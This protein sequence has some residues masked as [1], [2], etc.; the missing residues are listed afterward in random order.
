MSSVS[1]MP[2]VRP[3]LPFLF[4]LAFL[5]S[6]AIPLCGQNVDAP[7]EKVFAAVPFDA[8]VK[9]GPVT[10]IPWKARIQPYGLSLHQRMRA[11]IDI[12][13]RRR[14][15]MNRQ[16]NDRMLVLVQIT[17]AAGEQF[18]EYV[19]FQMKDAGAG[20]KKGE[21]NLTWAV[22]V[23]PGDYQVTLV[24]VDAARD[25]H[26]LIQ[27]HMHVEPLKNDPLP[28]IWIGLPAVEFLTPYMQG[29]DA[30][31]HPEIKTRLHLPLASQHPV[32]F[33]VLADV[34]ASDLFH[35]STVFY[36]RYLA[37]ALPLLKALS[38]VSL[39]QGS[40]NVAMLD[41]RKRAVTF[42]EDDVKEL[43]WT[44]AK[45][46]L[47][48]ENGPSTIDIKALEQK[49]E[50]PAFLQ[51][52]LLR[53][54]NAPP[55]GAKQGVGTSANDGHGT[56]SNPL[57]VFVIIGSPMDFYSFRDLPKLPPGSEEK[58]VVYYLQFELLNTTYAD[59]AIGNV[60]KMLKPLT[61]HVFKVRSAESVRH[62][63]AKIL[64]EVAAM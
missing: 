20:T 26:N 19:L 5:F 34:T 3:Y 57:H 36:D 18:R 9:Q 51:D 48:P 43:D 10:A 33:D 44:R 35:G 52:E 7:V 58:C 39:E 24:L 42:E 16:P 29:P 49:R 2:L 61:V 62:A 4:A 13:L 22:Y 32:E 17:D 45:A 55:A 8:W 38:Q 63:L 21:I 30:L 37:V 41:L 59:G 15:L 23:L 28:S 11:Y 6:G 27:S 54:L 64:E 46:V 14:E 40:V 12:E 53:R 56:S 25:K 50:S 1:P 60:R 31:F 47:A